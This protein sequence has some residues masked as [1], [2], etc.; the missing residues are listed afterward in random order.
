[1]PQH[2][3]D[4][5]SDAARDL[6][7]G[8]GCSGCGT[9]GRVLCVDCDAL[10]PRGGR[11]SWPTPTPPGLAPPYAAGAY[12]D[13]LKELVNDHKEHG[14]F[15]LA[16]PLGRVLG[17]VVHQ[18]LADRPGDG[19]VVLVPVPSRRTVVRRRGH[20]PLLRLSR[21]AGAR[22]R[23]HGVPAV[24]RQ[25]LAPTGPVRDQSMLTAV[26]RAE[27]LAGTM[28]L[29]GRPRPGRVVLVDDVLTT[30]STVREAQRALESG[31]VSVTG[32]AVLA[33]TRRRR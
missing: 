2:R 5:L 10:L 22:L 4:R 21:V 16:G 14:V 24:V 18:L 26:Q 13:L 33:A 29:R 27:N 11:L 8:S 17:D 30:G 32:I 12:D 31:G 25:L 1:M 19:P 20:D 15:G 7:L 28:R 23:L 3:P 9:P 6:V